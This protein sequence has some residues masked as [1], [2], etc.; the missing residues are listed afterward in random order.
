MRFRKPMIAALLLTAL[1]MPLSSAAKTQWTI[2]RKV[3]DVDTLIYPHP[4][5]PGVIFAKYDVP[6]M[7]LKVSVME[8]DFAARGGVQCIQGAARRQCDC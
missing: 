3:Y 5:G 6:G 1:A 7:P 2:N 8:M 4:V